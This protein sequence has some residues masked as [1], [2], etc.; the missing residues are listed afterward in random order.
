LLA[1][2]T[3]LIAGAIWQAR[4]HVERAV[5]AE[6]ERHNLGRY[7]SPSVV[8][9]LAGDTRALGRGRIH[10]A[11]V[12]FV[13]IIGST[14][15]AEGLTPEQ[16]IAA[17]RAF[18]AK[19][20]PILFRYDGLIDKF[21]GDGVMAVFGA[22]EA[23]PDSARQAVLCA[24]E[25]LDEFDR[26]NVRRKARGQVTARIALGVHY[27]PVIQGNVGIA[28]RLEF[29]ALGDTVNVASRLESMTRRHRA[30][31]LLSREALEA[32]ERAG[33]LPP[34]LRERCRDLGE[35]AIAGHDAP[36]HLIAIRRIGDA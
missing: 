6:A 1:V 24:V 31:I 10:Q 5:Q 26:W 17:V 20:V 18:H 27:G 12:L 14:K 11:A 23:R 9:R 30:A 22:P 7:F 33:P 34:A 28:D 8:D 2:T 19:V 4:R 36:V 16:V 15:L 32:A 13:D 3:G 25:I 21:L 29:T 35:L